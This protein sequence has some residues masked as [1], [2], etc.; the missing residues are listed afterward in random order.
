MHASHFYDNN[1]RQANGFAL[2]SYINYKHWKRII[3]TFHYH[4][5]QIT[6]G[7]FNIHKHWKIIILPFT[8]IYMRLH[9]TCKHWKIMFLHKFVLLQA[10]KFI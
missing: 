8:I 2:T 3:P 5:I 7:F 6:Y 4:G 9:K 1:M 10:I